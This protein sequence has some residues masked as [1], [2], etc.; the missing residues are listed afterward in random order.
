M[1]R[2]INVIGAGATTETL[3]SMKTR[4][5]EGFEIQETQV[6]SLH[7]KARSMDCLLY[8]NETEQY[9]CTEENQCKVS[10]NDHQTLPNELDQVMCSIHNKPRSMT[11]ME[12][13]QEGGYQCQVHQQCKGGGPPVRERT[14]PQAPPHR[15]MQFPGGD[16]GVC[17]LHHKTRSWTMLVENG[18]GSYR[19]A[20]PNTCRGQPGGIPPH[21]KGWQ[22][23]YQ[24][25][26]G[27][28]KGMYMNRQR[29]EP[30]GTC[31]VHGKTRT[32][33]NLV[34]STDGTLEC[35]V[36]FECKFTDGD[37]E[38]DALTFDKET[39][40]I[41]GKTRSTNVLVDDG[42]GGFECTEHARCKGHNYGMNA[43]PRKLPWGYNAGDYSYTPPA[44]G[45]CSIHNKKRTKAMLMEDGIGGVHCL[46]DHECKH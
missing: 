18:Y 37:M 13:D 42:K 33:C 10:T 30:S 7:G 9:E 38:I 31:G 32:L 15:G 44:M 27:G 23:Y 46:P 12:D 24:T 17:S 40:S 26:K 3:R 39:C 14:G 20:P 16:L 35:A 8:D 2:A 6:C 36:G 25:A 5:M 1:K 4:R 19:C 45:M 22:P 11:V 21:M 43:M 41:H 34:E 28:G 29:V